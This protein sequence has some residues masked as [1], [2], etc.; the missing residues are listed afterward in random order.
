MNF[1]KK[2]HSYF[3]FPSIRLNNFKF[4]LEQEIKVFNVK[5]SFVTFLSLSPWTT[6]QVSHT[7]AA[8]RDVSVGGGHASASIHK[9]LKLQN[10]YF[11]LGRHL[12][13]NYG[14]SVC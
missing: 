9:F 1:K 14:F 13:L 12:L 5:Y 2:S 11:D 8:S 3:L 10:H 7:I 4:F 6:F